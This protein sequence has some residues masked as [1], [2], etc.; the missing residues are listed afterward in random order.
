MDQNQDFED[1]PIKMYSGLISVVE[2]LSRNR[3]YHLQ[4][5]CVH[6]G[7]CLSS[8]LIEDMIFVSTPEDFLDVYETKVSIKNKF[9]FHVIH[10]LFHVNL[11]L[12]NRNCIIIISQ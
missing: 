11:I 9:L 8:F 6:K 7:V 3:S 12:S 2:D 10:F 1:K 5:L 4:I